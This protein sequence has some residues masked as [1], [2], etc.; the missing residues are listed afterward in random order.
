MM[1]KQ[2]CSRAAVLSLIAATFVEP[3]SALTVPITDDAQVIT[4]SGHTGHNYGAGVSLCIYSNA[5]DTRHSY[6][7]IKIEDYVPVGV[8]SAQITHAWLHL[9]VNT[10][11]TA[12]SYA[13]YK[14]A[15]AWTEGKANGAASGSDLTWSNKPGTTGS[16]IATVSLASTDANDYTSIEITQQVKDW[17]DSPSTNYGLVLVPSGTITVVLNSKENNTEGGTGPFIDVEFN[18][19]DGNVNGTGALTFSAGGTNSN[20]TLNPTG[21]GT[22]VISKDA[23]INGLTIG[24]GANNVV[25]NTVAGFQTFMNNSTGAYNTAYGYQ[26]LLGNTS[27]A[28]NTATGYQSLLSNTTGGF[29]TATGYQSLLNNT[30]GGYNTANGFESLKANV[31]GYENV[32]VGYQALT[33]NTSGYTGSAIGFRA[34]A[35][36]TTGVENAAFG[37]RSLASNTTGSSNTAIGAY[38]FA[39][40]VTN[41]SSIAVGWSAGWYQADGSTPLDGV[42]ASI[43]IGALSRGYNNSDNNSI[44]IGYGATGEGAN[45]TVVG[46][47]TTTNT[48]TFG[49]LTIGGGSTAPELRIREASGNGTN[50]TG[51]KAPALAADVVYTLPA[52]DGTSGQVLSTDGSKTLSWTSV[53]SI[54]GNAATATALQTART[55][56]GVAF[57]GTSN[58]TVNAAAGGLTGATLNSGVI[59]SSL[60]SLGTV[61][62][63]TW[64]ATAVADSYIASA[65]TW[66]A[67]QDALAF[68]AGL[69]NTAGTITIGA[70]AITNSMLAGS[71]DL[72]SKVTGALPAANGGTGQTSVLAS[73]DAFDAKGSDL[74]SASTTDLSTATG[75]FVNVTGTATIAALGTA[76]AG[77]RR[78]VR[79]TGAG[80]ITYHATS[81]ILPGAADLTRAVGDCAIFESLGSGNWRC[82][83]YQRA[84]GAPIGLRIQP[85]GDVAMDFHAGPTP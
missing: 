4:A 45:T 25:S 21:T 32:G 79:F 49:S 50:F 30:N 43:Y 81:L 47:G 5:S 9:Y 80:T 46:N 16:A 58:I 28:K 1:F 41:Q 38:A 77:V 53:A 75:V 65:S 2:L 44:V 55:I 24:R 13:V 19:T 85:Q 62:S 67:K 20:I 83:F 68:G 15:G 18:S 10:V 14:A 26:S 78:W 84:E 6:L 57:D 42:A 74:A 60:T 40:S 35:S 22:V 52:A 70:G 51:F 48:H 63:G 69:T 56:N 76:P 66:H 71:I 36:N 82:L 27:G 12:G 3:A 17:L 11:T 72:T 37:G 34:L 29:N 8:T 61:T 73:A 54:S 31:G 39:D 23:T 33:A 7:H 59:S 64:Q